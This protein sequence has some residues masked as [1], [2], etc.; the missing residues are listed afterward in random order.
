MSYNVSDVP[1]SFDGS[2]DN[3]SGRQ[4]LAVVGATL[5]QQPAT[6]CQV[7]RR[8][9]KWQPVTVLPVQLIPKANKTFI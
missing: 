7:S 8:P 6:K 4:R 3:L 1:A 5:M 9:H 2:L